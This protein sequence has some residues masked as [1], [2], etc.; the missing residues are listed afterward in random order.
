MENFRGIDDL[1]ATARGGDKAAENQLFSQLHARILSL[2]Q[3]RIWND[4]M[5][6]SEIQQEAENLTQ[7]ISLIILQKYRTASFEHGFLPWVFQIVQ[8]KI[9]QYYREQGRK[10]KREAVVENEGNL[11]L[12]DKMDRPDEWV[13]VEELKK[14]ISRA[15]QKMGQPCAKIM[16]TLLEGKIKTYIA[17]QRRTT[18][19]GTIYSQIHRC[20]ELFQRLLAEAGYGR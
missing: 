8:N 12:E 19:E 17:K 16:K 4:Q 2:V 13:E 1:L 6:P 10:R 18:P 20:R 9:G 15:L 7:D 11:Q 14:V 3:R 5:H